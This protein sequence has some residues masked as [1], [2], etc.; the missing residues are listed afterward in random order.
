MRW[1]DYVLSTG[2][3]A[4]LWTSYVGEQSGLDSTID[5]HL[6]RADVLRDCTEHRCAQEDQC[7]VD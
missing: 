7:A 1:N 4:Y 2:V 5:V 3:F 6:F